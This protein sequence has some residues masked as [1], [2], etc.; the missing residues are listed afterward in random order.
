[1][2]KAVERY[3]NT[4]DLAHPVWYHLRLAPLLWYYLYGPNAPFPTSPSPAGTPDNPT[5]MV[6]PLP[7]RLQNRSLQSLLTDM[8]SEGSMPLGEDLPSKS[9]IAAFCHRRGI[10]NRLNPDAASSEAHSAPASPTIGTSRRA[11]LLATDIAGVPCFPDMEGALPASP[12]C[13]SPAP[14]IDMSAY[15]LPLPV[16]PALSIPTSPVATGAIL[17]IADSDS[18]PVSVLGRRPASPDCNILPIFDKRVRHS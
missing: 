1:M 5:P 14:V 18:Q 8:R 6:P 17:D 2:I 15:D 16:F 7:Q 4:V 10:S 11:L 12:Q 13:P 9:S 3:I